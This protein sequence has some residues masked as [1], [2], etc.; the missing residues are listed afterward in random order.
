MC[1][2]INVCQ[3]YYFMLVVPNSGC[4]ALLWQVGHCCCNGLPAYSIMVGRDMIMSEI[5]TLPSLLI[6]EV[7]SWSILEL[8]VEISANAS[9][10]DTNAAAVIRRSKALQDGDR[11]VGNSKHRFLG[12]GSGICRVRSKARKAGNDLDVRCKMNKSEAMLYLESLACRVGWRY[13]TCM[14]ENDGKCFEGSDAYD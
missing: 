6:V 13:M 9:I 2:A 8:V 3:L 12:S 7:T 14:F 5:S 11:V 1:L 10:Y 4:R